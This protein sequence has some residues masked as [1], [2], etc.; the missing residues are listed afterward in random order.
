MRAVWITRP[1]G[2]RALEVR[3][4]AGVIDALG[5][6]TQ[7]CTVGQ[8]VLALTRF[9]GHADVVCVPAGQVLPMPVTYLTAY[10]ML[11]RVANV[12]PGERVLVHMAAA[13]SGRRC[14]NCAA[15]WTM[16]KSSVRPRLPSTVHSRP[17][18]VRTRSTVCVRPDQDITEIHEAGNQSRIGTFRRRY[19]G[20]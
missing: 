2:P 1:A 17:K 18:A 4:T 19:R 7:G 5:A 16:Q 8:R 10:H 14:C 12:R 13:G 20:T 6:G 9:G 15:P 3:E 11:F